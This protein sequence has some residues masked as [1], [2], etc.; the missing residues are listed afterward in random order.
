MGQRRRGWALF[1]CCARS[2]T[3]C[4]VACLRT[5]RSASPRS[6]T[7]CAVLVWSFGI[8][9][10]L[11]VEA[12]I[13]VYRDPKSG[14]VHFTNVPVR[15]AYRVPPYSSSRRREEGR[16]DQTIRELSRQ[17]GVEFALIKAMIKAESGFDPLALS[18]KGAR[19]LMQLMP[20]TAAL[21][22]VSNVHSPRENVKGGVRHLR[23][24]LNRFRG[25]LRL[26]LA[27][28]NAGAE[29]VEQYGG[30]PPFA[31]TIEY[32]RRVLSYRQSYL[33][34][35]SPMDLLGKQVMAR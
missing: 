25:N 4:A 33:R 2:L 32:V 14:V 8:V 22:G 23:L 12:D 3:L 18:P 34:Q 7:L 27:A 1:A 16:Y 35:G 5:L 10:G 21:H 26:A 19:G 30:V 17:Y 15:P 13:Y 20:Q 11:R 24:L 28:Y 29:A 6:L 31:E 9:G